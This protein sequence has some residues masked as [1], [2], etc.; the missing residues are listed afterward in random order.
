MIS[1]GNR[2]PLYDGDPDSTTTPPREDQQTRRSSQTRDALL[3]LTTPERRTRDLVRQLQTLGHQVT[4]APA[5]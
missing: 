4:L 1:A 2:N 5:A 3:N